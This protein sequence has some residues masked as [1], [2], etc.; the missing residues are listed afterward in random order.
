MQKFLA[1]AVL[2]IV[3]VLTLRFFSD[4]RLLPS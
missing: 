4:D 1:I 2:V 3:G